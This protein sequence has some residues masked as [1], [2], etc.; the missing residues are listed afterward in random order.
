MAPGCLEELKVLFSCLKKSEATGHWLMCGAALNWDRPCGACSRASA[1]SSASGWLE[2]STVLRASSIS[3][4]L[5][6]ASFEELRVCLEALPA[7]GLTLATLK[8]ASLESFHFSGYFKKLGVMKVGSLDGMSIGI[9]HPESLRELELSCW[10]IYNLKKLKIARNWE[11][12]SVFT[13]FEP[14]CHLESI[15]FGVRCIDLKWFQGDVD[16]FKFE[17][18]TVHVWMNGLEQ[19]PDL[20]VLS[21]L[22]RVQLGVH[23]IHEDI[24]FKDGSSLPASASSRLVFPPRSS[25]QS[26]VA[27]HEQ[28][29]RLVAMLPFPSRISLKR[30]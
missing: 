9:S 11:H 2:T 13:D 10:I 30:E 24:T 25:D 15:H 5:Q 28:T 3:R 29:L 7:A 6:A 16:H 1:S 23:Y 20:D 14:A 4:H 22:L 21:D 12:A 17:T 19:A 27:L 8:T 18:L 26:G